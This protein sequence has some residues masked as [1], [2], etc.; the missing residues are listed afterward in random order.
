MI[1]L[2]VVVGLAMAD[3]RLTARLRESLQKRD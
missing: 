1:L 3:I 2:A